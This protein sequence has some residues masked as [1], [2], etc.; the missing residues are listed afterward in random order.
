HYIEGSPLKNC[1]AVA[2][3]LLAST[4]ICTKINESINNF[5]KK[6]NTAVASQTGGQVAF[7][8]DESGGLKSQ[9]GSV[10]VKFSQGL[11]NWNASAGHNAAP[12]A[13][14]GFFDRWV[15]AQID[16]IKKMFRLPSLTLIYPKLSG[17]FLDHDQWEKLKAKEPEEKTEKTVHPEDLSAPQKFVNKAYD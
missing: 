3:P 7:V 11:I 4:G 9:G 15:S 16:E 12:A 13:S 5:F 8:V 17:S 6:A 14:P 1:L 10:Q 2:L